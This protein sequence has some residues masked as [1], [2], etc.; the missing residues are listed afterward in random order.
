[1]SEGEAE[2]YSSLLSAV[3]KEVQQT[4]ALLESREARRAER[5]WYDR[6]TESPTRMIR[7]GAET[8]RGGSR[9][10]RST[11]RALLRCSLRT[12]L[13]ACHQRSAPFTLCSLRSLVLTRPLVRAH[14]RQRLTGQSHGELDESRIVDGL[15]GDRAVYRR[16]AEQPPQPGAP[17]LKPKLLRRVVGLLKSYPCPN[18]SR[19]PLLPLPLIISLPPPS[20]PTT[21]GLSLTALDRCTIS[22]ATTAASNGRCRR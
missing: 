1:M 13:L 16:R 21:L 6:H 2:L 8:T 17:Q 10:R 22:T 19:P 12:L 14:A 15:A 20:H 5:V 11:P 3:T 18:S 4:R 7:H 9:T